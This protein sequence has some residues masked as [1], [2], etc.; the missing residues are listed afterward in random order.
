M[1]AATLKPKSINFDE[2]YAARAVARN[3][4]LQDAI[5]VI[6]F[7]FYSQCTPGQDKRYAQAGVKASACIEGKDD[8]MS[9]NVNFAG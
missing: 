4:N 9:I 3:Q 6:A 2:Q 5:P 8:E 7:L 1:P